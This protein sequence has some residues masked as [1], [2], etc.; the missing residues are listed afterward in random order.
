MAQSVSGP[1]TTTSFSTNQEILRIPVALQQ[2]GIIMK[3]ENNPIHVYY[4][5]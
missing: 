3:S 2:I 5:P 1:Q 4:V